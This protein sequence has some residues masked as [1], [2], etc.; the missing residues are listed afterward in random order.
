M[1]KELDVGDGMIYITDQQNMIDIMTANI[2]LNNLRS[3][4]TPCELDW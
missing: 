2:D 4:I 1:A 3:R